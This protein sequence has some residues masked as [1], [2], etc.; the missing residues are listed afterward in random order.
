MD[1]RLTAARGS[2][3]PSRRLQVRVNELQPTIAEAGNAY[4]R[5][6]LSFCRTS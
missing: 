5:D 1:F 2:S 3:W 6:K 4:V